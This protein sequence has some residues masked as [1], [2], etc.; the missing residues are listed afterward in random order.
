MAVVERSWQAKLVR[1]A[2]DRTSSSIEY[3]VDSTCELEIEII[4]I[5]RK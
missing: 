5:Q 3:I 1:R 2:A 4:K